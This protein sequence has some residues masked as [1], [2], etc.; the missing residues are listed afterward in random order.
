[1]RVQDVLLELETAG[2]VSSE[3]GKV[4]VKPRGGLLRRVVSACA[5][6]GSA[7]PPAQLRFAA[8]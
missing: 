6:Q 4:K 1:M 8:H 5:R 7:L 2:M 3:D